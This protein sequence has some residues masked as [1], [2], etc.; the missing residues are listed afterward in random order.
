MEEIND[1][2]G[3]PNDENK[4]KEKEKVDNINGKA[5]AGIALVIIGFFA[6]L[7]NFN[8]FPYWIEDIIFSWPMLLV[9]IGAVMTI[10]AK[11]KTAG[12]IVLAVGGFFLL[13]EIFDNFHMYNFFWPLIFIIIGILL[14]TKRHGKNRYSRSED[15]SEGDHINFSNVFSGNDKVVN[16]SNFQG[17]KVSVVFGGTEIDLTKATLALG[18]NEL[19][20]S[21]VFG[22][23]TII[24]PDDWQVN[25][26]VSSF[27]G[28]F[29]DSRKNKATLPTD[30]TRQ[31]TITGAVV[32]GGGEVK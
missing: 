7:K 12:V 11:E 15:L 14:I 29:T 23:V 19:D 21:C 18:D 10:Q 6:L 5:I 8:V 4:S 20:I 3:S 30:S 27:L 31:L 32:F 16:S 17:G 26:D 25:M 22:G 9:V 28:G 13:P 2:S 24:V 1:F